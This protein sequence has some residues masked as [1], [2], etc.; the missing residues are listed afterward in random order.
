MSIIL[1]IHAVIHLIGA[2]TADRIYY[3][4]ILS[5]LSLLREQG[6]EEMTGRFLI[7][8]RGGVSILNFLLSLLS[9]EL[10]SQMLYS[11]ADAIASRL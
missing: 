6:V 5:D 3:K 10:V 2:L 9:L 7:A 1:G 11:L 8:R 4:K